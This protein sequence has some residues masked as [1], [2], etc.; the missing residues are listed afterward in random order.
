V[1]GQVEPE[2]RLATK[3]MPGMTHKFISTNGQQFN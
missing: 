2:I 3:T 1:R